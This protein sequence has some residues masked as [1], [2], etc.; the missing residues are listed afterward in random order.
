MSK[1][2]ND[3]AIVG[4]GITGLSAGFRL[5]KCGYKVTVFEKNSM[6][7]GAVRSVQQGD[8]LTEYGPNTILLKDR[9]IADLFDE[10]SLTAK[11]KEANPEASKRYIVK[12][13]KLTALPGSMMGAIKTPLFSLPGKLRVLIEPFIK[14]SSDPDQTVADFVE[15]RLGRE[16]LDYAINPFVAGIFANSPDSLSLRHAFPVMHDMEEEYG[17]LIAGALLGAQKRRSEG[18]I[19]RKLISFDNVLQCVPDRLASELEIRHNSRVTSIERR[20][21]GWYVECSG[22]DSGPYGQLIMNV[23]LYLMSEI[24]LPFQRQI[25]AIN[26]EVYYPPLS[27]IHIAVKKDMVEHDLDGFGF[28]VPEKENRNILGALFSSTLFEGRVP[29]D[30]HLLTVFVGGGRQPELAELKSEQLFDLVLL[31]LKELIGLKGEPTFKDHV[32]W[33]KSIP[34]YHVGYDDIEQQILEI[35]QSSKELHIAGNFRYGISVPDC[36]RNGLNYAE[37]IMTESD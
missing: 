30:Q 3:I 22:K 14:R 16:V 35:E 29:L 19:E 37:L 23:P 15:R 5:K 4:S 32:F 27:V 17:S 9:V 31:E 34:A 28:L 6:P 2:N 1:N 26:S 12:N 10:L 7:G 25:A 18:R 24:R 11:I 8:Y 33:P 36:I 20:G 13:G 21:D